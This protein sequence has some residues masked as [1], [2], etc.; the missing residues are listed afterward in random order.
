MTPAWH[1]LSK[2]FCPDFRTG[3]CCKLTTQGCS[4]FGYAIP[5]II[6][7]PR[8]EGRL[9]KYKTLME[10]N[11]H[12]PIVPQYMASAGSI[13]STKV[14]EAVVVAHHTVGLRMLPDDGEA[15][16]LWLAAF[17]I[18]YLNESEAGCSV[19]PFGPI[20]VGSIDIA[21]KHSCEMRKGCGWQQLIPTI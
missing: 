18:H 17:D 11:M 1:K 2:G 7:D 5:G 12:Q 10:D 14:A 16:G 6:I 21:L 8:I 20:Q 15:V 3:G 4:R 19:R 13:M 9:P